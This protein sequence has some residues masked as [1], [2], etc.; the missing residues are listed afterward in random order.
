M[1]G[2]GDV[3]RSVGGS[4]VDLTGFYVDGRHADCWREL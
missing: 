4:D 2:E 1:D 3:F